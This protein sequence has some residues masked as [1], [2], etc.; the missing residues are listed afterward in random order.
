MAASVTLSPAVDGQPRLAYRVLERRAT[1]L[2]VITLLGLAAVSWWS[3]VDRA[4]GMPDMTMGLSTV[5]MAMMPV[6]AGVFAAMWVTM[7][8]AMMFPT[9]APVVLL[10]R[11]VMQRAGAGLGTSVAF[12]AGYLAVWVLSGAVPLAVLI[13][14]RD[15]AAGSGWVAPAS[16][17]VLV[18]AGLYQFTGWKSTCLGV[19]QSPLTF[20]ATHHFGSGSYAAARAGV[21]HGLYCLGCCWALMTVLFVVGL[22]NLVWMAAISLVFL[23]EKHLR[24]ARLLS[25]AVGIAVGVLGIAVIVHPGVLSSISA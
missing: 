3:V 16:G 21:S 23:L 17:V 1:L 18:V 25:G 6:D 5:G 13:L 9:I 14:V 7:M 10:H 22:M 8:V 15:A 12:V 2:M 4:H 24:H 11:M 19:C 20:L